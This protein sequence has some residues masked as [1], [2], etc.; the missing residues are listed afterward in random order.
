M[1]ICDVPSL[2]WECWALP[3]S[4]LYLLQLSCILEFDDACKGNPGKSGAGVIIRRLDGSVVCTPVLAQLFFFF[5][6]S[7]IIPSYLLC[8]PLLLKIA[9]LREG[10]GVMTNNAAEY[11]ALIL[12]LNYASKKG[13]KYIRCQGDSKLVCNQVS[14]YFSAFVTSAAVHSK[15]SNS[16]KTLS[17]WR[18]GNFKWFSSWTLIWKSYSAVFLH[19][20]NLFIPIT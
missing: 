4:A 6:S 10:L 13:F 7:I 3:T 8:S 5:F 12:G 20:R 1:Y 9:L 17:V 19:Q 18:A 15:S 2:F 14:C 11:R 16:T